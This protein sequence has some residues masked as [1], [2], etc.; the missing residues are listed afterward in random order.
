MSPWTTASRCGF[1][2]ASAASIADVGKTWPQAVSMTCTSAPARSAISTSR[3]P[4]RPKT[5]TSTRSPGLTRETMA[6][7]MPAREVPSTSRVASFSVAH[8]RRYNSW[9][10]AM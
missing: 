7:S 8:S 4:N 2:R 3:W 5:G 1:T 6:A 10:S 9:V